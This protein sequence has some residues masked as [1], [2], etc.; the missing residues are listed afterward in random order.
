M[1]A[2]SVP[3]GTSPWEGITRIADPSSLAIAK[4][5]P[6]PRPGI[7]R[8]PARSNARTVSRNEMLG[9]RPLMVTSKA[10][11]TTQIS[12][13]SESSGMSRPSWRAAS[14]QVSIALWI[15]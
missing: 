3:R 10:L 7:T 14:S 8:N 9:S 2:R 13:L 4:W 1:S 11:Y 6:L 15:S 5:L 12:A